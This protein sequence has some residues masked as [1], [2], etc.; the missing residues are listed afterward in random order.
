MCV[1]V[2]VCV[3]PRLCELAQRLGEIRRL[4]APTESVSSTYT[5]HT[6]PDII[7]AHYHILH[8]HTHTHTHTQTPHTHT[9]TNTHINLHTAA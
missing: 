3:A 7:H 8:T 2:Y 9:H 1:Y 5:P 4:E 6:D